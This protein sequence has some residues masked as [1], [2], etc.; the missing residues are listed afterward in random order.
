[1][2]ADGTV[3]DFGF[4]QAGKSPLRF[5]LRARKLSRDPPAGR[6]TIQ[7]K[8]AGLAIEGW[9]DGFHPTLNG[10][11]IALDQYERSWSLAVHP[12]GDR[13]VLGT[14]WSLR[15]LDAKGQLLWQRAAP[16]HSLGGQHYR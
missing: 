10:K 8:Q 5:D 11:P 2:S 15:A 4:E 6:Q 7:A 14:E 12:D 16:E 13:F 9:E 1:M 3:I